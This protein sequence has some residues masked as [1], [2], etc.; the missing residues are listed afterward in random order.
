MH[1]SR[2]TVL[3]ELAQPLNSYE[4][5]DGDILLIQELATGGDLFDAMQLPE[6]SDALVLPYFRNIVCHV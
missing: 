6:W 4:T 2:F 5:P 3:D 1:G